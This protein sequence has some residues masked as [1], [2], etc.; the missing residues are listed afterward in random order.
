MNS[1]T[2]CLITKGR[3]QFIDPLLKSFED[4]LENSNFE[5]LIILN[6][7][8]AEIAQTYSIWG[9]NYPNQVKIIVNHENDASISAFLPIITK[10]KSDWICFPSD[11]DVLD[12]AFFS[13][14]M[15]I[16]YKYS[17]SGVIATSLNLIDSNGNLLGIQ[18]LP[19]YDSNLSFVENAAKSFSE[20]PFLWPGLIIRVN[21]I[22][23]SSPS[24]RYVSDW[25]LGLYLIFGTKVEVVAESFTNYRVHAMQESNVSSL[26]R[27]N[28]E[29]LQ[30]LG[31]FI[32]S[33]RFTTW[34]RNLESH[35]VV[36]FLE[37]LIKYPPLYADPK[38]SREFVSIISNRIKLTRSETEIRKMAVF[39]NA[40]AHNVI[41][42]ETQVKYVSDFTIS[43]SDEQI[44]FNF[45]LQF[46][47]S[48]CPK[49]KIIQ[50]RLTQD[51][52]KFPALIFGC[53][54]TTKDKNILKLDC[55]NLIDESQIIDRIS[56]LATERFKSLSL[57]DT[58]VSQF[59]YSLV[60]RYRRIK[61]AFPAWLNR[62]LYTIFRK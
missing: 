19:S 12:S 43:R 53:A 10:V 4:I 38:F 3:Q 8:P 2:F 13:N 51:C 21:Q 57:F 25:W 56:H 14:W 52:P 27:K 9:R 46:D 24:S 37:F 15:E 33:E 16:A 30:H 7:A 47:E 40:L 55:L 58:S 39:V 50:A 23:I 11:D 18:R 60:E 5:L 48:C 26:S 1:L 36:N 54:H 29:A 35:E 32:T 20:C 62:I 28:F 17:Q 59:E 22:P 31:D 44:A 45:D 49:I 6:G 41:I 61:Y 34:I 42:D